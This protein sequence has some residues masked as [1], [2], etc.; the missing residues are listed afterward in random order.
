MT[1]PHKEGDNQLLY[2]N[3]TLEIESKFLQ[4]KVQDND[5]LKAIY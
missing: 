1:L 5:A 3:P 2:V 4:F